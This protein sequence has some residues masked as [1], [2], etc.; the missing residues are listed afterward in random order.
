[1]KH[2][3][4]V[5]SAVLTLCLLLGLLPAAALPAQAATAYVEPKIVLAAADKCCYY[6]GK[7]KDTVGPYPGNNWSGAGRGTYDG[8]YAVKADHNKSKVTVQFM[9]QDHYKDAAYLLQPFT[10]SVSVP[11]YTTYTVT[12][13]VDI[14]MN[15]NANGATYYFLEL[16]DNTND[17]AK[18]TRFSAKKDTALAQDSYFRAVADSRSYSPQTSLTLKFVNSTGAQKDV[19]CDFAFL[20]GNSRSTSLLNSYHHMLYTSVKFSAEEVTATRSI[21]YYNDGNLYARQTMTGDSGTLAAP[22]PKKEGYIFT[23]WKDSIGNRVY[24]P[25][26]TFDKDRGAQLTAQWRKA[27]V[28]VTFD[29]NGGYPLGIKQKTKVVTVGQT[30]GT[31]PTPSRK[32]Y[33]FAGWYTTADGFRSVI[34]ATE[35]TRTEDHT[36]YACWTVPRYAVTFH[37]NG[38][39]GG[40]TVF[41]NHGDK[42][43]TL[44]S[45]TRTGYTLDGWYTTPGGGTKVTESTTVTA[46]TTY[47][48]HWKGDSVTVKLN[49]GGAESQITVAYGGTYT[50]L[51]EP[52]KEGYTFLGWFTEPDTGG[53]KVTAATKVTELGEHTLYARWKANSHTVTFQSDGKDV[54]TRTVTYGGKLGALPANPSKT[55]YTFTGWSGGP[56]ADTVIHADTVYTAQWTVKSDIAVTFD[57][58]YEGAAAQTQAA[59]YNSPYPLPAEPTRENY[60]FLGWYTAAS[61]G[62]KVTGSTTVTRAANH[63]LYAR[64]SR[65]TA[66]VT[67]NAGQGTV[68]ET[69]RK[70][71]AGE[72]LGTL[73]TPT[74]KGY[75]FAGWQDSRGATATADTTVTTNTA[76]TA[77]WTA[78][79][80]IIP[81]NGEEKEIRTGEPYGKI[82]PDT[83]PAKEG[84][85]QNGWQDEQGKKIDPGA[86]VDPDHIPAAITPVWTAKTA[87]VTF[88]PNGGSVGISGKSVT[89]DA[90]YGELPVPTNSDATRKFVGWQDESGKT[91]TASTPVKTAEAHTLYAQWADKHQHKVDPDGGEAAVEFE[92]QPNY[93]STDGTGVA[94]T[95]NRTFYLTEDITT[96]KT[97]EFSG[98]TTLC[99]NGH[100]LTYAGFRI[101]SNGTLNICDC[102][103]GGRIVLSSAV[104]NAGT[105]NLYGGAL[106]NTAGDG[107]EN[108]STGTV[109]VYGGSVTGAGSA[110]IGINNRNIVNVYGGAVS[111]QTGIYTRD[112]GT[113]TV[114][115]S[116]G[117]VTGTGSAGIV[118]YGTLAVSGGSVQGGGISNYRSLEITGGTVNG[119]QYAVYLNSKDG[120][121]VAT[122]AGGQLHGETA[123]LYAGSGFVT[124]GAEGVGP[125][126][127]KKGNSINITETAPRSFTTAAG[128]DYSA[129]FIALDEGLAFRNTGTGANQVVELYAQHLHD[130]VEY[131][132]APLTADTVLTDG[133]HYLL[134]EDLTKSFTIPQNTTVDLCLNGHTL[135]NTDGEDI[136]T[137]AGTLNLYDCSAAKTGKINQTGKKGYAVIFSGKEAVLNQYGGTIDGDRSASSVVKNDYG[138]WNFYAGTIKRIDLAGGPLSFLGPESPD[139]AEI[140]WR[141]YYHEG[142][143]L[144][145]NYPQALLTLGS[146][147]EKP[148]TPYSVGGTNMA[149]SFFGDAT[150]RVLTSGW[151]GLKAA[152]NAQLDDYFAFTVAQARFKVKVDEADGEVVLRRLRITPEG[153]ETLYADVNGKITPPDGPADRP[154]YI[155]EGW[156]TA[157]TG[158]EAVTADTVFEDDAAIYPRWTVCDHSGNTDKGTTVEATCT[159]TG[160]ASFTC[161][162]CGLPVERILP[163]QG[164]DFDLD[165]WYSDDEK[166]THYHTC[167]REG[168]EERGSEGDHEWKEVEVSQEPTCLDV[169]VMLY[170]CEGCSFN[171]S[172]EIPQLPHDFS[173]LTY[174]ALGHWNKCANQGCTAVEAD[175]TGAVKKE[176]HIF[177]DEWV[178]DTPAA[179][180]VPGRRSRAC[181]VCDYTETQAIAALPEP[182]YTV[183]YTVD[184]HTKEAAPT[185]EAVVKGTSI[186]LPAAGLTR[187]GYTLAGWILLDE[188]GAPGKEVLNGSFTMPERDVTFQVRWSRIPNYELKPDETLV[189]EDGTRIENKGDHTVTIDQGGDGTPETTI[190]LPDGATT[191]TVTEG[192]NGGKDKVIVPPGATVE[193]TPGDGGRGP[194]ITIGN[195]GGKVETTGGVEV[196]PGSSVTDRDGNTITITEGGGGT[197]DPDG[198]VTFPEGTEGKVTVTTPEGERVEV[199]VPG[200]GEGLDVT[201]GGVP[202]VNNPDGSLTI[203]DGEGGSTTIT[204]PEDSNKGGEVDDEGNVTVPGGSKVEVTDKDG[205]KTELDIPDNGGVIDP[206]TGTVSPIKPKPP[207]PS[208]PSG[209]SSSASSSKPSVSVTGEG[210]TAEAERGGHVTI[211]PDEGYE[212]DKITVNGKEVEP[213]KDGKL[214]GLKGSDKVVVSFRKVPAVTVDQFDDVKPGDWFYDSVEAV[215]E[216][217][218]MNGVSDTA[219]APH[220]TTSR[221]MIATILWRLADSPEPGAALTYSDCEADSWYAKAVAWGA[222]EGVLKGYGNGSFGP[223][224]PITREQLAA[225]LWRYAG[226]PAAEGT[227]DGFADAGRA[228]PWAVDALRWAVERGILTGRGGGVLDPTGQ[229]TR[230]EAAAMLM[231]YCRK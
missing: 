26:D 142:G 44:P 223:G 41:L 113:G 76:Y 228:G 158:G 124:V 126:T 207:E 173:A 104:E 69:S 10:L 103:G 38:G 220:M 110:A 167:K 6:K 226:E 117:T 15:R 47:Y 121:G 182:T 231:R 58:N 82:L 197:I 146:G 71:N 137:L 230:A 203:P 12:F 55:G 43:G 81:V 59:T 79:T 56:T 171:N 134:T 66:T 105:L 46:K 27:E 135:S 162:V 31:L 148:K 145:E 95:A 149:T 77:Q 140:W 199:T 101:K 20:V 152:K 222:R 65:N 151:S 8:T 225:M 213:P 51:T 187:T 92:E 179:V 40:K 64:W 128:Q 102:Q 143:S 45:A 2:T 219:F 84:Y 166:D 72:A 176:A 94:Y 67:F 13:K 53:S 160:S 115:M 165:T 83:L 132:Y 89:Y 186:P 16:A 73:P 91:V 119:R 212:V 107:V 87:A 150:Q 112:G 3:K 99:L 30:Y 68:S 5:L 229:A 120:N 155:W 198:V 190:T 144:A 204:V 14:Y 39:S 111:G 23:G 159:E 141:N 106:T 80:Y 147:L 24:Q 109:N 131:P 22:A 42:L 205:N 93:I 183:T 123:D 62:A 4:R 133:G 130:G 125:Y 189:L 9:E 172:G 11:A 32:D 60:T 192:E 36:L 7:D 90:P 154:G 196:P 211:T 61:G 70:V 116:G 34:S 209:G 169:G 48:A 210:G 29:P 168:C 50:G 200:G 217:G 75:T 108:T 96:G 86:S 215:A 170:T 178:I 188:E 35:V 33:E 181:T 206:S 185:Q 127:V 118:N 25:G 218:L 153:G 98:T 49:D 221:A 19:G 78:K 85:D 21:L 100:T 157:E 194:V 174:D 97:L 17:A 136:I 88:D 161:S 191:V 202:I 28:T 195:G 156:Y 163:A 138:S 214:T 1:M 177:P 74:R 37:A 54:A 122:L 201:P 139:A 57:P 184:D 114:Y 175:E 216:Q 208:R 18:A 52:K 193:T 164:H 224:D 180:G 129:C 63:T 227:L